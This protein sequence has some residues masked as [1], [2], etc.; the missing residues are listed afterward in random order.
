MS[1]TIDNEKKILRFDVPNSEASL[2]AQHNGIKQRTVGSY[3]MSELYEQCF[4]FLN[5]FNGDFMIDINLCI[6]NA[7][8]I[9]SILKEK[10]Y[11]AA[12]K[13]G[14][15]PQENQIKA[16]K[17]LVKEGDYFYSIKPP[18]VNDK[19]KYLK[20]DNLDDVVSAF[21]TL[22]LGDLCSVYFKKVGLN[23]FII[24]LDKSPAFDEIIRSNKVLQWM[25]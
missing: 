18:F 25:K 13:N 20:L 21:K 12:F 16:L 14:L 23:G 5:K 19:K 8:C 15:K 24:Y 10:N 6:K 3:Y 4:D 7:E 22:V 2:D 9:V 17:W 1:M 11:Y